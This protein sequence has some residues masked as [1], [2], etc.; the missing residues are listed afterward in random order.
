MKLFK[1]HNCGQLLYFENTLC[2]RCEH[3]LGYLDSN[4]SI[5]VLVPTKENNWRSLNDPAAQYRYCANA[6]HNACNWLLPVDDPNDYCT[7]CQ[8]NRTIPDLGN[9][10][11]LLRWQ[12]LEMAK[13]HL[14]YSLI[15]VN[16]WV[17]RL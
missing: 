8:L 17:L 11:Y 13:H 15:P 14:V 1:C 2:T 7:A 6:A 12:K 3:A 10:T 5:V 9:M 4:Q 16:E